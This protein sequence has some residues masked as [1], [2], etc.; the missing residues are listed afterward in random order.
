MG[1]GG[2][3]KQNVKQKTKSKLQ[4]IKV[5]LEDLYN[6]NKKYLEISRYRVCKGCNGSG[7]KVKDANTKCTGCNGR[8]VKMIQRQI[9]M[10]IIQQQVT[11]P[12]CKGEGSVIKEKDK[13]KDCKGEKATQQKKLLE[14]EI[15]KGANDGKRYTFAGESDEFP[16]VE[17]GD[18]IIELN[19]EKHKKFE[20]KGA[21][22]LYTATILLLEALTGFNLIIEHL[23][24]RKVLIQNKEGDV[25]KPGIILKFK[26]F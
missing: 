16:D 11:C 22:L 26:N 17:P 25:V 8:G 3:K 5:S 7:S 14:V 21:D 6:G 1:R 4:Q 13:C 2:G 18:I 9:P 24:G 19:M 12:D 15:E 10:G 23:D 20:R